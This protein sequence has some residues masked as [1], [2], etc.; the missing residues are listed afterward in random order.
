MS[1][2]HTHPELAIVCRI[3]QQA[4]IPIAHNSQFDQ[5]WT[6]AY[7][8]QCFQ[9]TDHLTA[10]LRSTGQSTSTTISTS[11]VTEENE[12]I[13][14]LEVVAIVR[15]FLDTLRDERR[16]ANNGAYDAL[17]ILPSQEELLDPSVALQR[18][19]L[20]NPGLSDTAIIK[21]FRF[22]KSESTSTKSSSS[23]HGALTL[24]NE[25][26]IENI[27][28]GVQSHLQQLEM[29]GPPMPPLGDI[30]TTV[31]QKAKARVI[32]SKMCDPSYPLSPDDV[33]YRL[34]DYLETSHSVALEVIGYLSDMAT[35][36]IVD[37]PP[38]ARSNIDWAD[39]VERL[40]RLQ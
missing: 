24:V 11:S 17:G 20:K 30:E 38:A 31:D 4:S 9:W 37:P 36:A 5:Q 18:R 26:A 16:C 2:T 19:L 33:I 7:L 1:L 12:E 29:I 40:A 22:N 23:R 6:S 32:F 10:L 27:V 8:K 28:R 3:L 25:N 35:S 14:Q 15:S 21:I 34:N 13:I 39:F